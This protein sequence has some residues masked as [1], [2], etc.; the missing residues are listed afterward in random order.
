M[1]QRKLLA[2]IKRN[3]P[4]AFRAVQTGRRAEALPQLSAADKAVIYCYTDDGYDAL[5]QA[6]YTNGGRNTSLFGQA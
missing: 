5:N 2:Y 1:H 4:D 6:L 3:L